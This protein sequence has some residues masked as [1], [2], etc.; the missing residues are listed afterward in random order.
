VLARIDQSTGG[1]V[2]DVTFEGDVRPLPGVVDA[3]AYRI[4]QEALT[5]SR[6]HAA[7]RAVSLTVSYRPARLGLRIV[8]EGAGSDA[9]GGHGLRGMRERA[10]L[11]GGTLRAG[12]EPDGTFVV[13]AELPT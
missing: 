8:N 3:P 7:G 5:N 1:D 2:V 11:L 4:V 12:A 10:T 6:R 9:G 13:C